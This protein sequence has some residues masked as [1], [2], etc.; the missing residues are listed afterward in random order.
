MA[1]DDTELGMHFLELVRQQMGNPPEFAKHIAM[2]LGIT[3]ANAFK[4]IN[5]RAR[6]R[7]DEMAKLA[8]EYNISIDRWIGN[9]LPNIVHFN[10]SGFLRNEEDLLRYL[11][12][13]LNDLSKFEGAE[14]QLHYA[15]RDLPLFVYFLDDSLMRF[16]LAIWLDGFGRERKKGFLDLRFKDAIRQRSRMLGELYMNL[17]S[18]EL[19]TQRTIVNVL[20]QIE[21]AVSTRAITTVFAL[22]VVAGLREVI[23]RLMDAANTG[24]KQNGSYEI[25]HSDYLMMT[26]SALLEYEGQTISFISYAGVNYLRSVDPRLGPD[27]REWFEI[28]KE[29]ATPLH[30]KSK[31]SLNSFKA[32]ILKKIDYFEEQLMKDGEDVQVDL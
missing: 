11:T 21:S 24:K 29:K 26:N 6:L 20:M 18:S 23:E 4:R 22:E 25:Y 9:E 12:T 19:W 27:L 5:G 3:P 2:K 13:T 14:H 28:T 15:A 7:L 31:R 32:T 30:G 1:K 16:K 8:I 17:N 10:R